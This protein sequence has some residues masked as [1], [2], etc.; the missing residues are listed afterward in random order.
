MKAIITL[1]INDNEL[2]IIA[3]ALRRY[4]ILSVGNK[5]SMKL[6]NDLNAIEVKLEKELKKKDKGEK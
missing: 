2:G 1:K 4:N 5:E 6:L 3:E